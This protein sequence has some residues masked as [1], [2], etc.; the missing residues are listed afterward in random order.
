MTELPEGFK[1]DPTKY[2]GLAPEEARRRMAE[3][4]H[5]A[6]NDNPRLQAH[7]RDM[8]RRQAEEAEKEKRA[9]VQLEN[10]RER[11]FAEALDR[12]RR[13]RLEFYRLK[14]APEEVFDREIWPEIRRRFV[15]GEEDAVDRARRE[16]S[17]DVY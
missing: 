17:T 11:E 10:R 4:E 9:A 6:I 15:A 13:D 1:I 8:D 16:R 7:L 12:H 5:R 2:V 3:D 14:G